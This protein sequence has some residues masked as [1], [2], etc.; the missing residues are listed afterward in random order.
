MDG[1]K[2]REERRA[3]ATKT[4]GL[5]VDGVLKNAWRVVALVAEEVD[6]TIWLAMGT[7][8][9]GS[10]YQMISFA[11]SSDPLVPTAHWSEEGM[12]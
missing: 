9:S 2:T 4:A 1:F 12:L 5:E 8:S 10:L 6:G 7:E 3:P 11:S